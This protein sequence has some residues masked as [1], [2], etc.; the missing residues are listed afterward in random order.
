VKK[1]KKLENEV[2]RWNVYLEEMSNHIAG[3][4]NKVKENKQIETSLNDAIKVQEKE[5][6]QL[7]STI[8][9]QK[10]SKGDVENF[11]KELEKLE[12]DIEDADKNRIR[13]QE[14][15]NNA[16][17]QERKSKQTLREMIQDFTTEV[18][19]IFIEEEQPQLPEI[20]GHSESVEEHLRQL[21]SA[22]ASDNADAKEG[23]SQVSQIL[24]KINGIVSDVQK[25]SLEELK[26]INDDIFTAEERKR[27]VE[28][29][30]YTLEKDIKSLKEES[31]TYKQGIEKME[32]ELKDCKLKS[33]KLDRLKKQ[34]LVDS[35]SEKKSIPDIDELR[36]RVEEI[37]SNN[38]KYK[39]ASEK[40]ERSVL[41]NLSKKERDFRKEKDRKKALIN[42]AL[43]QRRKRHEV[44][45]REKAETLKIRDK[46]LRLAAE[47]QVM[48]AETE[49]KLKVYYDD[50]QNDADC[51]IQHYLSE[52]RLDEKKKLLTEVRETSESLKREHEARFQRCSSR[53]E[54]P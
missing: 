22:V 9:C 43:A 4:E 39:L 45:M 49:D 2:E 17:M 14:K 30:V 1:V 47:S 24:L 13:M 37:T 48:M 36:R 15:L 16:Q 50:E 52:K 40:L 35:E 23:T 25:K 31:D 51:P 29:D 19:K 10:Y 44:F 27:E 18:K 34:T 3:L 7:S 41:D 6:A 8:S 33:E 5:I 53:V 11:K 32:T 12:S 54:N 46:A 21:Y 20:V 26:G 42:E 38:K 28:E